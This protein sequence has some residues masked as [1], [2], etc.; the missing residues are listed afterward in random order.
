MAYTTTR[1]VQFS[2]RRQNSSSCNCATSWLTPTAGVVEISG[3]D[4]V[5][6][7]A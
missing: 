6:G 5:D 3:V 4:R 1:P 7:R 2:V